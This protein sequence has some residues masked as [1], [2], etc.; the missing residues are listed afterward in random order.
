MKQRIFKFSKTNE[1]FKSYKDIS[2]W[3]IKNK[4]SVS[5]DRI[6]QSASSIAQKIKKGKGKLKIYDEN[7]NRYGTVVKLEHWRD[8]CNKQSKLKPPLKPKL[9]SNIILKEGD[10]NNNWL[11]NTI[12][13]CEKA[14]EQYKKYH[15]R[16]KN[17]REN[18]LQ[19]AAKISQYCNKDKERNNE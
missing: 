1:Y 19:L 15:I 14:K 7:K 10:L 4:Y 2:N 11:S 5:K 9:I 6:T 3:I 13:A 8:K 17:E 18:G 12:K 16:L